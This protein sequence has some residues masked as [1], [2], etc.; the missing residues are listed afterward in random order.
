M[1]VYKCA[2]SCPTLCDPRGCTLPDS[3]V[4]GIFQARILDWVAISFSK[5]SPWPKKWTRSSCCISWIAGF[6]FFFVCLFVFN[7]WA[8]REAPLHIQN[9]ICVCASL[10]FILPCI[11]CCCKQKQKLN[12]SLTRLDYEALEPFMYQGISIRSRIMDFY[13][14]LHAFIHQ[15]FTDNCEQSTIYIYS[16]WYLDHQMISTQWETKQ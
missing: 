12:I 14:I 5:G 15:T 16:I 7:H 4:H 1:I 2:Q 3:S 6:W 10:C 11:Q 13:Y 9:I 8:T